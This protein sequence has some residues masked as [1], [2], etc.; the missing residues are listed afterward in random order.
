MKKK[1]SITCANSPFGKLTTSNQHSRKRLKIDLPYLGKDSG[2][3]GRCRISGCPGEHT[4]GHGQCRI[5]RDGSRGRRD[6]I[7]R[8]VD[9]KH[10]KTDI[11]L[12][13]PM[14]FRLYVRTELRRSTKRQNDEY[15]SYMNGLFESTFKRNVELL[16][17]EPFEDIL[18]SIP[19][20]KSH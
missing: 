6:F 12:I 8:I 3:G 18:R 11:A 19:Y 13:K 15:D 9:S 1:K 16:L 10:R 5:C 17:N 14:L 7:Q 2:T 20:T 4:S